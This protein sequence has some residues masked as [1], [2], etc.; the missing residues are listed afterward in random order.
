MS[1][2]ES[3]GKEIIVACVPSALMCR[4]II[5]SVLVAPPSLV[6]LSSAICSGVALSGRWSS[7]TSRMFWA[8]PSTS[9]SPCD[10]GAIASIFVTP[11]FRLVKAAA[12]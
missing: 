9:W 12:A 7:P 10:R 1:T 5:V 11:L 6:V 8:V 3:R 4:T 2:Y